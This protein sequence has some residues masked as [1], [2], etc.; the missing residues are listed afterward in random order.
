MKRTL[1]FFLSSVLLLSAFDF[2]PERIMGGNF[3]K[4]RSEVAR[5]TV[6]LMF[7]RQDLCTASLIAPR[8]VLTAAHCL[9][10]FTPA[11]VIHLSVLFGTDVN[12]AGA[13]K[14]PV[15]RAALHP[16]YRPGTTSPIEMCPYNAC[17]DDGLNLATRNDFAVLLL[18]EDAPAGFEP[19]LLNESDDL[20][21]PDSLTAGYGLRDET[22]SGRLK[23]R[24]SKTRFDAY[25]FKYV[26]VSDR[27]GSSCSG[28][29]G[30]PM[31]I[32]RDGRLVQIGVASQMSG[33]SV[34]NACR[35]DGVA[36]V[37][38]AHA[39]DWIRRTAVAIPSQTKV[40]EAPVE[41]PGFYPMSDTVPAWIRQR[42]KGFHQFCEGPK[43]SS[44]MRLELEP[45]GNE[46]WARGQAVIKTPGRTFTIAPRQK[47]DDDGGDLYFQ[48]NDEKT[49]SV[50]RKTKSVPLTAPASLAGGTHSFRLR[51]GKLELETSTET[52]YAL[53]ESAQNKLVL[54]NKSVRV[55]IT[56]PTTADDLFAATASCRIEIY[57]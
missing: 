41:K 50:W 1:P 3:E 23:S 19:V 18:G 53:V 56:N 6:A 27:E 57:F 46:I 35:A 9:K 40:L 36:Y 52:G 24:T 42:L 29:S 26:S 44:E 12:G 13:R 34:I 31:F 48:D 25:S 21:I 22:S 39:K 20:D 11:H 38:V 14:V 33:V 45:R 55:K 54:R 2:A 47:K 51:W 4:E 7:G 32:R 8:L 5:H 15:V 49:R 30:G 37:S 16:D 10:D 43:V 28:D 17:P